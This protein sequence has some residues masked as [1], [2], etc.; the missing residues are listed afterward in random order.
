MAEGEEAD[1]QLEELERGWVGN[2]QPRRRSSDEDQALPGGRY[3]TGAALLGEQ[4]RTTVVPQTTPAPPSYKEDG[5]TVSEGDA[6]A[7][8]QAGLSA[9]EVRA[10]GRATDGE[11]PG[12]NKQQ[13]AQQ[14]ASKKACCC[15]VM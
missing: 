14:P 5:A 2:G 3:R 8:A 4:Q 15:T 11:E 1:E 12:G 10:G 13:G 6:S 9:L 7:K